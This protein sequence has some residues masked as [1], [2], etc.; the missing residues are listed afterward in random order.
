MFG[1]LTRTIVS[2][3]LLMFAAVQ[4]ATVLAAEES[5]LDKVMARGNVIVGVTSETP[6]FGFVDEKGELTGFDVD[7]ARLIA[8]NLFGEDGHIEFVKQG[9]A[10][11]WANT[12]SG[13]IDFGIQVTTVYP[14][15]ALKVAFTRPYIDSGIAVLVRKD[16]GV[17]SISELNDAKYTASILTNPQSQERHD[18]FFPNANA[19][20]FDSGSAQ[21]AAVK[22]GRAQFLQIDQPVANYYAVGN[23]DVMVL[24]ELLTD[25]TFNAVFLKMGDFKWWLALDTI[26]A[27]FR[28]GSRYSQ[29]ADVY[30]KWFGV[31]PPQL[32]Y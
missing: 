32:N 11:R 16:A 27:T 3:S 8:K 23:D 6:P 31:R 14:E 5:V 29:Y 25:R 2:L 28:G 1:K 20:V 4:S 21:F 13:K 18:R 12:Q 9:F 10:A 7:I 30:E 17:T 19:S 15:R 24:P 22:T 26:V